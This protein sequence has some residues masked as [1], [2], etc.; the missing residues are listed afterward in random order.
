MDAG[1]TKG[2][3]VMARINDLRASLDTTFLVRWGFRLRPRVV[4]GA[5]ACGP[6]FWRRQGQPRT[7]RGKQPGLS[8]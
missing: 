6:R 4:P 7:K 8:L 3:L 5:E 1:W 2:A